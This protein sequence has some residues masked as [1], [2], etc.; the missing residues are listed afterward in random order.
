M[1]QPATYPDV[2]KIRVPAETRKALRATGAPVS[3]TIRQAINFYLAHPAM[4]SK[5]QPS[6]KVSAS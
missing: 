1:T 2:I 5:P 4:K 3:E 6:D